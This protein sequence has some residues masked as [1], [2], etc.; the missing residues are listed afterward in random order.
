VHIAGGGA[1]YDKDPVPCVPDGSP[2][3]HQPE[4]LQERTDHPIVDEDFWSLKCAF[5]MC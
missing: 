4:E 1:R 3:R 5:C 2:R